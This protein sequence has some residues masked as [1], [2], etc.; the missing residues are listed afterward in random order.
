MYLARFLKKVPAIGEQVPTAGEPLAPTFGRPDSPQVRRGMLYRCRCLLQNRKV[1]TEVGPGWQKAIWGIAGRT[2]SSASSAGAAL[3]D[4]RRPGLRGILDPRA[5]QGGP[6]GETAEIDFGQTESRMY[7]L[8]YFLDE[9]F[10]T[11][12]IFT[13]FL[14]FRRIFAS[15]QNGVAHGQRQEWD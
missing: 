2:A 4:V 3:G 10:P 14:S 1:P 15:R 7:S 9:K 12:Y 5:D 11:G 13:K 6:A 8:G